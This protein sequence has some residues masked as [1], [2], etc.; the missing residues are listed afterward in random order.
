M[1]LPS[2]AKTP[3]HVT[4]YVIG[5]LPYSELVRVSID[6]RTGAVLSY[7]DTRKQSLG[8]RVEQHFTTVHFGSFGGPGISGIVVKIFWV[9]L[10]IVPALLAVTGLIMYWNRY[11]RQLWTR[12]RRAK[13]S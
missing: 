7:A 3:I 12:L 5:S 9:L 2:S 6:P 1:S 8:T 11:L 13:S 4:G 10:G